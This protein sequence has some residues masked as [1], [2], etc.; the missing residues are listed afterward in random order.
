MPQRLLALL[1]E[2]H[3]DKSNEQ[4]QAA[5]TVLQLARSP[6]VCCLRCQDKR[7]DWSLT[8]SCYHCV[9]ACCRTNYQEGLK[10]VARNVRRKGLGLEYNVYFRP[11]NPD[12]LRAQHELYSHQHMQRS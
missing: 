9:C 3:V 1:A 7:C 12:V 2:Q 4:W 8:C 11:F 5:T 6:P 10:H